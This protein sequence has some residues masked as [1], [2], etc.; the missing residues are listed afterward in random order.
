MFFSFSSFFFFFLSIFFWVSSCGCRSNIPSDFVCIIIISCLTRFVL[1]LFVCLV[2]PVSLCRSLWIPLYLSSLFVL[3]TLHWLCLSLSC[4]FAPLLKL[5]KHFFLLFF[6]F[7]LFFPLS[8]SILTTVQ[9]FHSPGEVAAVHVPPE[10]ISKHPALYRSFRKVNTNNDGTPV[11][12]AKKKQE[13]VWY[14]SVLCGAL[15]AF[16]VFLL[17][18]LPLL[19]DIFRF[20]F[21]KKKIFLFLFFFFD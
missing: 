21:L 14:E 1:G 19:S 12:I 9:S 15:T 10:F 13:T 17:I 4:F 8:P 3:L 11:R 2:F 18:V 16:Y 5:F 7:S 6:P 20:F